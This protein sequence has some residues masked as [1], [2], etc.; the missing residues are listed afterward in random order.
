MSTHPFDLLM[1][2]NER[3]IRLD[4]AALH[5][6]RD[7]WPNLAMP[8]CLNTLDRIAEEVAELRPG[9]SATLRYQAMRQ[10]LVDE[11][12]FTG[13][14]D[15]YFDPDNSYLNRVLDRRV[16]V[17]VSLSIIWIEIGRR[18][19]WPVS[20]LNLPGHFII[21][22]DDEERFIL[23]DPFRMGRTLTID[24]CRQ[25]LDHHYEGAV[26]FSASFLRPVSVPV[27]LRR[28]LGDLRY[29]YTINHDWRRLAS[30]LK[31]LSAIEPDNARHV[32]DLA[33][34]LY[35]QGDIL[36]SRAQLSSYLR[37]RPETADDFLAHEKLT[38][39]EALLASLN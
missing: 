27:I 14:E 4:C 36:D 1:E 23:V 12:K 16:G 29:L 8:A 22:F 39:L 32:H 19:K 6:A 20:G 25:V 13:A 10:V 26:P 3:Y 30:V 2:L 31:R 34:L 18:L 5:M 7:L 11:Y 17:P 38:H 21:R 28:L 15:D 35:R 33:S 9:L 37:R 24:D